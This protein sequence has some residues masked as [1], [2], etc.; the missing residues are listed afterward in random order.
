MVDGNLYE[1]TEEI[2]LEKNITHNIEIVIDRLLVKDGIQRRLA[3]SIENVLKLSEGLLVV[4]II[5]DRQIMFSQSFSCPD[6][7]ISLDEM[8]PRTFSFNNPFRA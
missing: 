4:D 5:G 2:K 1:L 6:C 7:G 3:D 8:E